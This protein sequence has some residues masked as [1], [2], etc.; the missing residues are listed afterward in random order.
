MWVWTGG[1]LLHAVA[2]VCVG[3]DVVLFAATAVATY[4]H[5]SQLYALPAP[6][7]TSNQYGKRHPPL[8]ARRHWTAGDQCTPYAESD[9][10]DMPPPC[11]SSRAPYPET[12]MNCAD[13]SISTTGP[14]NDGTDMA[15]SATMFEP[16][17]V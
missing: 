7:P 10:L 14:Q 11:G 13:I 15:S 1:S 8:M 16:S 5:C 6:S 9:D 3:L 12:I 4:G 17:P 2:R